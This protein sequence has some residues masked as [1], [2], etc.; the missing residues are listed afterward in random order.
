MQRFDWPAFWAHWQLSLLAGCLI[1][2]A[3][4]THAL[5]RSPIEPEDP[6][7]LKA[8]RARRRW[9][10]A[11]EVAALP[12]LTLMAAVLTILSNGSPVVA[13]FSGLVAGGV[14]FP[15]MVSAMRDFVRRRIELEGGPDNGDA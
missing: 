2:V 1:L 14:G 8:W 13:L 3:R 15:F 10:V 5:A 11:A 4:L 7:A 6:A 12:S 9:M